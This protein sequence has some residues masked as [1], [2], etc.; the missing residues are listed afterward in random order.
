MD[1]YK[2]FTRAAA[3]FEQFASAPQMTVETGLTYEEAREACRLFNQGRSSADI[4]RG[5]KMEFT[6]VVV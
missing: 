1:T 5:L 3:S 6:K 4:K 2:T